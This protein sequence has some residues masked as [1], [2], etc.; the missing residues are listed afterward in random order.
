[1]EGL[2]ARVDLLVNNAGF[3]LR[4]RFKDLPVDRQA[5]IASIARRSSSSPAPSC[6]ACW[7]ETAAA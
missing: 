7:S 2:G 3:G 6:P 5:E 1:V 4:G